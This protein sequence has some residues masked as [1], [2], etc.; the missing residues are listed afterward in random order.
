MDA[1]RNSNLVNGQVTFMLELYRAAL[2]SSGVNAQSENLLNVAL[3]PVSIALALAVISGGSAGNTL[4]EILDV[5]RV[6][7]DLTSAHSSLAL[8]RRNLLGKTSADSCPESAAATIQIATGV[9]VTDRFPLKEEYEDHVGMYEG[10][11]VPADFAG[12]ASQVTG[13]INQWVS[14]QTSGKIPKIVPD[15][16][17]DAD[18]LIL[19]V[20]ALYFKGLWQKV[21]DASSTAPGDFMIPAIDGSV[22]TVSVPM[23]RNKGSYK[24]G[25]QNGFL[26]LRLP[27]QIGG[28]EA[29]EEIREL[30][31]YIFLPNE[32]D[33]LAKMEES[34]SAE[35]LE[36]SFSSMF[37][38]DLVRLLVPKFKISSSL[39]LNR[40][41]MD[42]GM[43]SAFS[44]ASDFSNLF[45]AEVPPVCIS[46]VLHNACVEVDEEGTIAA[47]AT[48]VHAVARCMFVPRR[49]QFVVDHP[50]LFMIRE[51]TSGMVL[52]VGR[53]VDPRQS[54]VL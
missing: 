53:V 41:L 45:N 43:K 12:A 31:M 3:S 22:D 34:L 26:I 13:E 18:S 48:V 16:L 32:V 49:S 30:A 4:N 11:V 27:Y 39:N 2:S 42:I 46:D 9:W 50:F 21:F 37:K 29:E 10:R 38:V 33:G 23:M 52:F 19:L 51:D 28:A 36:E 47:A 1:E 24:M 54:D 14:K 40:A 5:L 25:E 8:L 6:P 35:L 15:G 7:R 17:L 20:N 44:P